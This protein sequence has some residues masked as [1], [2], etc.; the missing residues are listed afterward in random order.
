[1]S[2]VMQLAL[3]TAQFGMRYGIAGRGS[4]VPAAEVQQ[5]LAAAWEGGI[6]LLDTAPAYGDIEERLSKLTSGL[7]FEIVSKIPALPA[8]ADSTEHVRRSIATIFER[9]GDSVRAVLF[10]RGVDLSEADGERAW[11]A[12]NAAIAGKDIELGVSCY[13]P[14]EL[15]D[16]RARFPIAVAQLPGNA[17]DQRLQAADGAADYPEIHLRSAFLQGLLLM[18]EQE[19]IRRMPKA[20]DALRAWHRWCDERGLAP[21]VAALSIVKGLP[22]VRYCV[23]GV[24]SLTQLQEILTAWDNAPALRAQALAVQNDDVIDP[25]RW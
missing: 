19:A 13:S 11:S 5:I 24:D 21:L 3:G 14:A 25:R 2:A 8:A 15:H 23:V 7:R 4:A 18:P 10:H 12:A 17:L 9:L 1:M 22:A 20:A 6:R 16:L